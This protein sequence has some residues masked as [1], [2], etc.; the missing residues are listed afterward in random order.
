[1]SDAEMQ[2][3]AAIVEDRSHYAAQQALVGL[4]IDAG[5]LADA[6]EVLAE[7]LSANPRQPKQAMVL[8]RLQVERGDLGMATS[9]LENTRTYAGTDAVYLSFLAAVLQ[10]AGRHEEAVVQYRYAL[11]YVPRNAIWLMGL[12]I[13]LRALGSA[14]EAL[15]AF[16]EAAATGTLD[17]GLQAFVDQQRTQLSRAV[18]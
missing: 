18:N 4:L 12:G 14:G 5:R 10:R 15:Q 16:D 8:A 13:S 7:S 6:E 3:R 9:T 2:F 17:P 11:A 1:M